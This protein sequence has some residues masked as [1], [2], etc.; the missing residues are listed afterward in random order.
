[1]IAEPSATTNRPYASPSNMTSVLKRLRSRNLPDRIDGD[2]LRDHGIPD[3][4]IHRMVFALRF[5]GLVD[6]DEPSEAL[7]Q[8]ASSTDEEYQT[9]LAGLIRN[10]YRDIFD[11]ID[12]AED[13]Q[14]RILNVFRRYTPGSQRERMVSFFL[15]MC[16]EAGIPTLDAP[17][18]RASGSSSGAKATRATARSPRASGGTP[19][20][21]DSGSKGADPKPLLSPS[22]DGAQLLFGVTEDDIG[23]LNPDDFDEVWAALGKVA[24]A[25]AEARKERAGLVTPKPAVAD[26]ELSSEDDSE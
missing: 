19:A 8:I 16:R 11:V 12:P 18:Q 14:G 15:G 26:R 10:A 5:L 2:F 9:I 1:M 23:M 6:E 25:R 13:S 7:R 21:R 3:G 20:K 22:G 17:R 4:S 24:R